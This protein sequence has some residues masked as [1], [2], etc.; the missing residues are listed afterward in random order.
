MLSAPPLLRVVN[1]LREE[2]KQSMEKA[3][4]IRGESNLCR[5]LEEKLALDIECHAF[6]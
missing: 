6:Y 4:K 1:S 3:E 2:L 5:L